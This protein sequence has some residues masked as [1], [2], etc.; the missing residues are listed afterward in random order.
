MSLHRAAT[1][2]YNSDVKKSVTASKKQSDYYIAVGAVANAFAVMDQL[3]RRTHTVSGIA[4]GFHYFQSA[5]ISHRATP[6]P[7]IVY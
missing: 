4:F 3:V 6:L 5:L 1:L 7:R 2:I